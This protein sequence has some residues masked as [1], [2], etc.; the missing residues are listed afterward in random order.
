MWL[1][2]WNAVQRQK[3]SAY[4]G[5]LNDGGS[6]TFV[7]IVSLVP[8]HSSSGQVSSHID[9]SLVDKSRDPELISSEQQRMKIQGL[10]KGYSNKSPGSFL[11]ATCFCV[12]KVFLNR[13][14]AG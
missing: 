11:E 13:C 14:I 7:W 5:V 12:I 6:P 2:L 3:P 10:M 1:D 4:M 8:V 9:V